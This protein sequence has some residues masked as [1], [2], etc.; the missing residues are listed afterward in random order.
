MISRIVE[1]R[2]TF[3]SL[4][5]CVLKWVK[6]VAAYNVQKGRIKAMRMK[7]KRVKISTKMQWFFSAYMH[8]KW[9]TLFFLEQSFFFHVCTFRLLTFQFQVEVRRVEETR[10]RVRG[11]GT[12]LVWLCAALCAYAL[13][14]CCLLYSKR[15]VASHFTFAP[16]SYYDKSNMF[17]MSNTQCFFTYWIAQIFAN[18]HTYT[19]A[20]RIQ[21]N[22]DDQQKKRRS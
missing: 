12:A 4:T 10:R 2:K 16:A 22:D 20:K 18:A 9:M 15:A 21:W 1:L 19:K 5:K 3:F 8:L 7:R 11:W 17:C 14:T 13:Y 6:R